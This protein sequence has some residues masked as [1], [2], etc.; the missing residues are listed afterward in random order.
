[1][2]VLFFVPT[3]N[4]RENLPELARRLYALG[5]DC[6]MLIVDDASP[7]GT[8]QV[9]D[10]LARQYP[11]IHVLH[12][13]GKRGRGIAGVAG[14]RKASELPTQLVIEMDADL[15]HVPEDAL[16]LVAAAWG[17]GTIGTS[18]TE[19]TVGERAKQTSKL[20]D[21]VIGSRYVPG[22][23]VEGWGLYRKLNSGVANFISRYILGIRQ[24][25]ATSGYRCFRREVL[26]RLPWDWFISEGPSIVEEIMMACQRLG[27]R[28]VEVPIT[29][30]DRKTGTSKMTP[31]IVLK[32]IYFMV[33]MRLRRFPGPSPLLDKEGQG[34]GCPPSVG[35]M[36]KRVRPPLTPPYQGGEP[37]VKTSSPYQGGEPDTNASR[38]AEGK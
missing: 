34:G 28:V 20:P 22:G 17:E 7:D 5:L 37:D 14:L 25:D 23:K 19:G 3:Y 21:V 2:E 31:K 27:C 26:A 32:W 12:R 1:M 36:H 11:N 33:R 4:E 8:G 6:G 15:S 24:K 10:E 38:H 35:V 29:F 13:T 18:G 16:K 30:V 9:A